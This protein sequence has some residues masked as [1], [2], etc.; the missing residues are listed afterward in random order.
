[1]YRVLGALVAGRDHS[2]DTAREDVAQ[3]LASSCRLLSLTGPDLINSTSVSVAASSVERAE[4][5]VEAAH[6]LAAAQNLIASVQLADGR[7]R[8][9]FIR[10]PDEAGSLSGGQ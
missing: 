5:L 10:L 6:E 2:S 7:F 9:R 1:M 4:L 3:L 8:A